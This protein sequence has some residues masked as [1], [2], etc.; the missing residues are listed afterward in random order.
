MNRKKIIKQ[1]GAAL[2]GLT[3]M[4]SAAF[5]PQA[6][7]ATAVDTERECSVTFRVDTEG[8][9]SFAELAQL[10]VP[11]SLYRVAAV[12]EYGEYTEEPGFEALELGNISSETS[13]EEWKEKAASAMEVVTAAEDA[14]TPMQAAASTEIKAEAAGGVLTA[15]VSGLE[16]GMYLVAAEDVHSDLHIY[17]FQPYLLSL[18]D[19]YYYDGEEVEGSDIWVYDVETGLKPEQTPRYGDLEIIKR[20]T[21][22]NETL[23]GA[24]FVFSVEA[25]LDGENVYSDVVSIVFDGPGTKS[26]LVEDLPAG[27][28]VTVTEVYSGAGYSP[29]EG[30][31]VSQTVTII[32]DP[33]GDE[34]TGSPVTVEFEN[35]YDDHLNGGTSVVNHFRYTPA[36]TEEGAEEGQFGGGTWDWI[37]QTDSTEA[38]EA[39][40]E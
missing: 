10:S 8:D 25:E 2:L 11:V 19:N 37:Q 16:T 15:A 35:E 38:A 23:Q 28:V 7:A 18:P 29:S 31:A 24:S 40:W 5:L 34:I 32:A 20:L 17:S 9:G 14:G 1:G 21:S 22:Y 13:A 39:A 4:L 3:L 12:N 36:E 30:T 26:V 33:I 27:S 6:M